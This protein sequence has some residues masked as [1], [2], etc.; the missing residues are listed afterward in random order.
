[1]NKV[2]KVIT[3]GALAAAMSGC[4]V[5]ADDSAATAS[6]EST[7]GTETKNTSDKLSY[8][9]D[10]EGKEET[11][12]VFTGAD[13]TLDHVTVNDTLHTAGKTGDVKDY[14]ELEDI[15]NVS[16]DETFTDEG[17][18]NITWDSDGTDISYQGTTD[19]EIPVSVKITYYLDDQE[20]SADEIA[21][22]SGHVKIR[23]D[24][25]NNAVT[26]IDVNGKKEEVKVPFGMVTGLVLDRADFTNVT[27]TN[28]RMSEYNDY[29]I[30]YGIALPGLK[31]SL[32][33]DDDSDIDIPEYVEIEG[34]TTNF[35]TE[36]NMTIATSNLLNLIDTD[37]ISL[38]DFSDS[39]KDLE[40][41][42]KELVD[43][44]NSLSS[45][46][47]E[48]SEGA[49][50]AASGAS[51]LASGLGTLS[52]K[53]AELNAGYQ[54]IADAIL[55]SVNTSLSANGLGTVTEA[56]YVEKF[57]AYL[58]VTDSMREQAFE[59]IKAAVN[60]AAQSQYN[61]TLTDDQI[62]ALIY[63]TALDNANLSS[64]DTASL[65][66]AL[67]KTAQSMVSASGI[68]TKAAAAQKSAANKPYDNDPAVKALLTQY[69][70]SDAYIAQA[71]ETGYATILAQVKNAV[72]TALASRGI[73]IND[74]QA[75]AVL[76]Y[77]CEN[78]STSNP[79]DEKAITASAQAVLMKQQTPKAGTGLSN[80]YVKAVTDAALKQ[81]TA[82]SAVYKAVVSQIASASN[83]DETTAAVVLVYACENYDSLAGDDITAKLTSAANELNSAN[84][85]NKKI[86]AA[87]SAEGQKIING[88]LT[89]L[90]QKDASY[91]TLKSGLDSL[92]GI[93]AFKAGLKQYTDGV[94]SAYAGAQQLVTGLN[95]LKSGADELDS[96]ARE[97]ADG[98]QEFYD[99]GIEKIIDVL[100]G[101][102]SDV[103]ERLKSLADSG[104][105]YTTFTGAVEND[106]NTVKFIFKADAVNAD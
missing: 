34:D 28:G 56:D 46:A 81:N 49:A 6:P 75:A 74:D 71:E 9:S 98:M 53:S 45:G 38:G 77:S 59:T 63:M 92:N 58:G 84:S 105:D 82:V 11:V 62:K 37:E 97:L 42:G 103:V 13:G 87:S 30:V 106:H 78:Y 65:Q 89:G 90:V 102:V 5:E 27:V 51:Q 44:S 12:Y 85:I 73:T 2:V 1:M 35:S 8:K 57:S 52:S 70:Q 100:N 66:A 26:T 79:L 91:Q 17:D 3:A 61:M 86:T 64:M 40:D 94:D 4:A 50:S 21:G 55:N 69:M 20:M 41:A 80:P 96:G 18:G 33:L 76:A 31:D 99:E 54:Q 16:G 36:M 39:S 83:V 19:K 93:Y 88:V 7:S 48:L 68:G 67:T 104:A 72:N 15:E 25:T 43:G 10:E 24:Y 14:T 60:Q 22:K 32:S 101:D 95:T 23:Y 29:D 47:D